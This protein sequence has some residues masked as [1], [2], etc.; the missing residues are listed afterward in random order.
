MYFYTYSLFYHTLNIPVP[1][2]SRNVAGTY[3]GTPC[4]I[5]I[6]FGRV[7][8]PSPARGSI[9][10]IGAYNVPT[11][12]IQSLQI[13]NTEFVGLV[14][15]VNR[16]TDVVEGE[17]TKFELVDMRD[18]LHDKNV[19]GALNMM[20][21]DG[22]FYHIRFDHDRDSRGR[23]PNLS[24]QNGYYWDNQ[25][26][27]IVREVKKNDFKTLDET[28]D[29]EF[30]SANAKLYSAFTILNTL[31]TQF[32]FE[33]SAS[34]MANNILKYS[35]PE[36]LDWNKGVKIIDAIESVIEKNG[37][38]MTAWGEKPHIHI[39]LRG[40]NDN[41]FLN[42]ILSAPPCTFP[43]FIGGEKGQELN[44][45]GRHVTIIGERDRW[46]DQY[47]AIPNWNKKFTLQVCL[48]WEL[49]AVLMANDLTLQSKLGDM[50]AEWHD[51]E[52]WKNG[53]KRNE[54]TIEEY[55]KEICFKVFVVDL[56]TPVGT[57]DDGVVHELYDP[58]DESYFTDPADGPEYNFYDK[59]PFE[60]DDQERRYSTTCPISSELISDSERQIHAYASYRKIRMKGWIDPFD[61]DTTHLVSQGD[62]VSID[63]QTRANLYSSEEE[64]RVRLIFSDMKYMIT[65]PP[66]NTNPLDKEKLT[67]YSHDRIVVQL[68]LEQ[69]VYKFSKGEQSELPRIRE[70]RQTVSKLRKNYLFGEEVPLLSAYYRDEPEFD[71]A[72]ATA[73]EIAERIADQL[74]YHEAITTTGAMNFDQEC[75]FMCDGIIETVNTTFDQNN[76]V[77]E[78]LNLTSEA[79]D[80]SITGVII[81][82]PVKSKFKDYN[83]IVANENA[84]KRIDAMRDWKNKQVAAFNGANQQDKLASGNN[85]IDRSNVLGSDNAVQVRI[86]ESKINTEEEF[87]SGELFV[88][89]RPGYG[90]D[91]LIEEYVGGEYNEQQYD[92]E[93]QKNPFNSK[94]INQ[95]TS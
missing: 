50:P 67:S 84:I 24:G 10:F 75:G 9:Q 92:P 3:G 82:V 5:S 94:S 28:V 90:D 1:S 13:G 2:G 48:G 54:L 11:G 33:W 40:F 91:Q 29:M 80:P 57:T 32:N 45:K 93:A 59:E 25:I 35:R 42:R 49:S 85:W 27:T 70:K 16:T 76:G 46:E 65:L 22:K 81:G 12:T 55:V 30:Q 18:R 37:L 15:S 17:T 7:H 53:K 44:D 63:V 61:G 79:N 66:Q 6:N 78:T 19:Y 88:L 20:D 68:A 41:P 77:T 36:N 31:A 64:Y 43:F 26:K 14:T 87:L 8:G 51:P 74:L 71:N 21:D 95:P 83:E 62:G 56:S 89:G 69:Q 73:D 52:L 34:G 38:Q 86:T 39:T 4:P 60:K 23:L 47:A 72:T 58:E